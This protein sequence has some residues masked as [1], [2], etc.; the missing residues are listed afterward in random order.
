MF[1]G[2]RQEC[3]FSA[4]TRLPARRAIQLG[5]KSVFRC[6]FGSTESRPTTA[7]WRRFPGRATHRGAVV[8]NGHNAPLFSNLT[9]LS[10]QV[11]AARV[12]F[13]GA[14]AFCSLI[15]ASCRNYYYLRRLEAGYCEQNARATPRYPSNFTTISVST[16]SWFN[17]VVTSSR[18]ACKQASIP[19][20]S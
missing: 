2:N 16:N 6:A 10:S 13:W 17:C 7:S 20:T 12:C 9:A 14:R 18:F 19:R 11:C 5:E 4:Q 3:L 1:T 8:Q 15:S